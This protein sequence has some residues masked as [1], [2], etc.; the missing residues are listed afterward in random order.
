MNAAGLAEA[1]L[2]SGRN[3][4]VVLDVTIGNDIAMGVI[5]GKKSYWGR[6]HPEI[7]HMIIPKGSSDSDFT[8]V[9]PYHE[10]CLEGLSSGTAIEK[11]WGLPLPKLPID[12][13]AQSLQSGYISA[14]CANLILSF[15]PEI[16]LTGGGVMKAPALLDK[17]PGNALR[18]LGGFISSA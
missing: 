2:G 12:H 13:P 9:S 1:I 11:R 16:I 4:K 10:N 15:S 17:L 6:S 5:F 3:K 7:G 8:G 14:L 18:Q